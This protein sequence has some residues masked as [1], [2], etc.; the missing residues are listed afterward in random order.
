[1]VPPFGSLLQS[2][3]M[4][5]KDDKDAGILAV[6]PIYLLTGFTTPLWIHPAPCDV[7]DSAYFHF[8]PLLSGI[9]S[10]GVG[11]TMAS[12][13][14]S[15]FGKHF[16]HGNYQFSLKLIISLQQFFPSKFYIYRIKENS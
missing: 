12:V 7:T 9:L 3:F 16:Y 4:A 2:S 13:F 6:T 15:T 1:M 5:L 8:L 10:V 14:G 11:D